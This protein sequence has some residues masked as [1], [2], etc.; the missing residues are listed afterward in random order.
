V[1]LL[2]SYYNFVWAAYNE[3]RC[4]DIKQFLTDHSGLY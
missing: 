1:F 4:K 2:S 3:E